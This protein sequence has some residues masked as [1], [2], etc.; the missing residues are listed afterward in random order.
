M[1]RHAAE[2]SQSDLADAAWLCQRQPG[3]HDPGYQRELPRRL[4]AALATGGPAKPEVEH[5]FH[6]HLFRVEGHRASAAVAAEFLCAR[7]LS[8]LRLG[9]Y[10]PGRI[11]LRNRSEEHTSEL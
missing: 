2:R 11:H 8:D 7:R 1:R 5:G 3:H 10:L 4:R 6:T 9:L